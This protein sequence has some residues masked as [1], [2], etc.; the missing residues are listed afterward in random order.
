M[1]QTK[2]EA[3]GD[4]A[5]VT[6]A[7]PPANLFTAGVMEGLSASLRRARDE[8]KRALVIQADGAVFSGGA[9]VALFKGTSAVQ[10]REIFEEGT[11]LIAA[12]E[13]APFPVIAAVHGLCLAA[14][15]ELALAS[16]LIIAAEGTQFAQVEALIGATTFL[17][18]AY[19]LAERCGSARALEITFSG[20]QYPADTFER[21]NIIN[22]VVPAEQLRD[23]ALAWAQ[24]LAKGPTRAHAVT[25]RLVQYALTHG[26]RE[27]DRF[28]LDGATPLFDTRDMQHAVD[29]M[30][31]QGSR[32]FLQNHG[33]IVFEGK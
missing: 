28:L 33:D 6:V 9:D 22:R 25:K 15:L 1:S 7:N 32:K 23:E 29:L 3:I 10:A 2:Y 16:D 4:V 27:A 14:G 13:D 21:W 24:R 11:A 26:P 30:L 8:D 17:G 20:Q 31:T 5:V 12:I 18:G 19:R